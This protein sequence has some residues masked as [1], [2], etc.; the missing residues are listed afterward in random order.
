[1][2]TAAYGEGSKITTAIPACLTADFDKASS[3]DKMRC[4]L[5]GTSMPPK[6]FVPMTSVCRHEPRHCI[7]CVVIFVHKQLERYKPQPSLWYSERSKKL[8]PPSTP[9]IFVGDDASSQPHALHEQSRHDSP[10]SVMVTTSSTT[11]PSSKLPKICCMHH[12]CAEVMTSADIALFSTGLSTLPSVISERKVCP[13]CAETRRKRYDFRPLP[14][15]CHRRLRSLSNFIPGGRIISN[16][17]IHC[18]STHIVTQ[19]RT[20]R[21]SS[22]SC[23]CTSSSNALPSGGETQF[24]CTHVYS[25][26]DVAAMR[27]PDERVLND[28]DELLSQEAI[29]Q[30]PGFAWCPFMGC[31]AGQ[32]H[33]ATNGNKM[34]CHACKRVSCVRH[35]MPWHEGRSC[36][37]YERLLEDMMERD[38][39]EGSNSG[40]DDGAGNRN[41]LFFNLRRVGTSRG[42]GT[43]GKSIDGF[44]TS[45]EYH[46]VILRRALC[47][48]NVKE[49]PKCGHGVQKS[50]GCD[51]VRPSII[52]LMSVPFSLLFFRQSS[53]LSSTTSSGF[54]WKLS[55]SYYHFFTNVH[56]FPSKCLSPN[57]Y[58]PRR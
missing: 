17:C 49:C 12:S 14:L 16:V 54:Q 57:L 56:I 21:N 46:E 39:G 19:V 55:I 34:R 11:I 35:H 8:Y 1:M 50:G 43:S 5:C 32:I 22:V 40:S 15:R 3:D 13:I 26:N 37:E 2:Q 9:S 47:K 36:H 33:D 48:H 41:R 38:V 44:E 27:L 24:Q 30:M 20:S 42:A 18:I 53:S 51:H 6:A 10:N 45:S 4:Q 7:F 52:P 29:E 58:G 25:R 31:G 23:L 28:L